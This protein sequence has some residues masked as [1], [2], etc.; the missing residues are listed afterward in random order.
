[1][2]IFDAIQNM[3]PEQAQ[4]LMAAGSQILQQSGDPRQQFGIGQ[5]V[6]SGLNTFQTSLA[7]QKRR[8]LEAEQQAQLQQIRAMQIR[9]AQS[10]YANQEAQR[11]RA[12]ELMKFRAGRAGQAGL[13]APAQSMGQGA[14]P[15]MSAIPM[16]SATPMHSSPG[17]LQPQQQAPQAAGGAGAGQGG[18]RQAVA[19]AR[20]AEAQEYRRAG[21]ITEA[22]AMEKQALDMQPKVSG[23]KEVR[24]G[25]RTLYAPYFEDGSNG[26]PVPL[27]V[28]KELEFRDA[29]G[30]QVG[31]D[32]YTGKQVSSIAKTESPDARASR[33]QAE[34]H[35][36]AQ[37]STPQYMETT[38]GLVA[39]PKRLGPGQAPVATPVMG[40]NGQQIE[41]K[42]NVPQYVVEGITG[43]AKSLASIRNALA[44]LKTEAGANGV[45]VKGYL[46]NFA[47]NRLDP[48]GTGIRAD[49]SDVG[50]LTLHD[51][52]GAA[53][54]ASES[55][56]LM[57]F[58]PLATDDAKTVEKKLKRMEQLIQAET[59]NL[60]F[61]F[62]Q[63]MKLA[64]FAETP[65]GGAKGG[66]S[67]DWEDGGA[68]AAGKVIDF[69]SLKNG[70]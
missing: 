51:R 23:W 69:G 70:R 49:I 45:G 19:A 41:K 21:F 2:G 36:N 54:T 24:D 32:R 16:P 13:A 37:Q 55:P 22:D 44:S 5:A 17:M 57:P 60:T 62:P 34:R 6:G 46:P 65:V 35:F 48:E 31:L 52:S 53:V 30:A 63:A 14:G 15:D 12:A 39:L 1:M 47:L 50:S 4:A 7:D 26:A 18:T 10:D 66:A 40:A 29:G 64:K 68:P 8:K 28:A 42:A 67:G 61:Q 27:E 33:A 20:L 11:A 58:I 59:N 3:S 9:D 56:R 43:N 25:G 38:D